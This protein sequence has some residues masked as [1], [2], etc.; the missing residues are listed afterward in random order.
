MN[1]GVC[2]CV[3]ACACMCMCVCQHTVTIYDNLVKIIHHGKYQLR[4]FFVDSFLRMFILLNVFE[5][6]NLELEC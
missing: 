5:Q 2:G 6:F 1:S 3:C 4:F